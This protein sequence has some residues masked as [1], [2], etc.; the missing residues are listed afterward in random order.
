MCP[1]M[2]MEDGRVSALE[3][4]SGSRPLPKDDVIVLAVPPHIARMLVPGLQT[5]T[6]YRAIV[7]AH[8]RIEVPHSVPR[9]LGLVNATADWIFAFEDRITVTVSAADHLVKEQRETL[10]R[11]LWAEVAAATGLGEDLPPW[12][13][14][15]ERRATFA[16]TPAEN[17]KRPPT[18]TA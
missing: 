15:R 3:F 13:I 17:A 6:T 18:R 1:R 14:V 2:T 8:Y 11:N 7:N 16:A 12:Q 4:G 10:A 5:P 9:I